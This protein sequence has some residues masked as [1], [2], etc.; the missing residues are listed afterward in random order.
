M[1]LAGSLRE[2]GEGVE[3]GPGSNDQIPNPNPLR[4]TVLRGEGCSDRVLIL[5]IN[6]RDSGRRTAAI[7]E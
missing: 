3:C 7:D 4:A 1:F 6:I 5:E 2:H